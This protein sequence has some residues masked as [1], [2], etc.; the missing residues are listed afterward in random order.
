MMWLFLPVQGDVCFSGYHLAETLT[1]SGCPRWLAM[2][3]RCWAQPGRDAHRQLGVGLEAEKGI[4][5]LAQQS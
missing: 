2:S 3:S 4:R 1:L 5:E